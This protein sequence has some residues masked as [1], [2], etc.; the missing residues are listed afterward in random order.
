MAPVKPML[1]DIELKLVQKIDTA[2][3]Q[4]QAQHSVPALEGDFLQGLGRRAVRVTLSGVMTGTEA[5]ADLKTLREKFRGAE[6]VSFVAD[7]ATATKVEKV[8][9]EEMG[10]R[11][12]AGKP[13]RFE[14]ALSLREMIQAPATATIDPVPDKPPG[15]TDPTVGT[16]IVEVVVEGE[17]DFDFGKV[18]VNAKGTGNDGTA[19]SKTLTERVGSDWTE[20]KMAPGQF[21]LSAVVTEEPSMSGT[22]QAT[23]RPG[24]TTKVVI[25]LRPG[26]L[27][28]KAYVI[29][30]RFDSAFIEPCLRQVLQRALDHAQ[31][32]PGE[33][34]LIV[35]HT[36][37]VG[38]DD[39]NQSLSERRARSVHAFLTFGTSPT[40]RAA[41]I[42]EWDNLRRKP[43]GAESK[44][45]DNWG[46]REYQYMLQDL[47]YYKG[48]IDEIHGPKIDSAI[49]A[50]QFDN[51]L[52]E[53]GLMNEA[54]WP[55][56]VEKYLDQDELAMPDSRFLPNA[57][58]QSCDGGLLKWLGCG[59]QDPVRNTEDAWRPNRRTEILFV[60]AK[61]LPCKVPPP[62]TFEL[63]V[64]KEGSEGP[65][66][67]LGPGD[68]AKRACFLAREKAQP[69]KWL[70][71]PA[72]P[73]KLLVNGRLVFVDGR[74]VTNE[75]LVLIAP[76]GEFLRR[77]E[78][79]KAAP[80]EQPKGAQRGRPIAGRTDA[81]GSFSHPVE[82]PVGVYIVEL[83]GLKDPSVARAAED[84]P[85]SAAGNIFCVRLDQTTVIAPTESTPPAVESAVAAAK[86]AAAPAAPAPPKNTGGVVHPAPPPP[87]PINP[88]ITPA[89]R[90]VLV[91]KD[92]TT[93][94]RVKIT[95]KTSA[96]FTRKGTLSRTVTAT[97]GDIRFFEAEVAT[98]G[99]KEIDL[100][101]PKG[102]TLTADELSAGK[103]I[104]AESRK[105]S[106]ALDDFQ[107]TLSLSKG[108]SPVGP[109][110][111]EKLTAVELTLDIARKRTAPGVDPPVLSTDDKIKKGRFLRVQDTGKNNLRAMLIVRKPK[112]DTFSGNLV[113][114][115]LDPPKTQV[116]V[117]KTAH[118]IPG[119]GQTPLG[120]PFIIK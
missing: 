88:I 36:D 25:T 77:D 34:V 91:K 51:E 71:Q 52:P 73:G 26:V 28:A 98:K 66:W 68:A 89:S 60:A 10:V 38:S 78:Q 85:Q 46:V 19:L 63:P 24:Q 97:S 18:T 103:A 67:C 118:E 117:F 116:Q 53:T 120:E 49:R 17:P 54:T 109:D 33:K 75:K 39:Y 45:N 112:P 50:F 82:T 70:V 16:L 11:E 6:P 1:D 7:I 110:A 108:P 96:K 48:K 106:G 32:N 8:L 119:P 62:V 29:H 58:G 21:Q 55:V 94:K 64:P 12:L 79:G 61:T 104:F 72:E 40:H 37:L 86:P 13:E 115:R 111:S 15:P 30:F 41:A 9:I 114:E 43:A 87:V 113:L 99:E 74:P 35:G 2:G 80:A 47:G 81:D 101:D 20:T 4:V 92:Y 102:H 23:V 84:P 3:E 83:P 59:E 105:P 65:K 76:D 69:G 14:Y 107:L 42:K 90:V 93:P 100:S 44:I 31:M 5:A 27:I 22:E 57:D 56:L 95:L